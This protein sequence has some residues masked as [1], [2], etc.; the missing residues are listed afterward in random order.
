MCFVFQ[1]WGISSLLLN[2]NFLSFIHVWKCMTGSIKFNGTKT[3]VP[4][5]ST[6]ADPESS[7]AKRSTLNT[8]GQS[9]SILSSVKLL[10]WLSLQASINLKSSWL[11]QRM[12][13]SSA[14]E[15]LRRL[16]EWSASKSCSPLVLS[17]TKDIC[18]VRSLPLRSACLEW[19]P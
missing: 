15:H 6:V 11:V 19:P 16:I 1:I 9:L 2:N 10:C 18:C 8:S 7:Q 13:Y 17:S 3:L 12:P 5:A 14:T 4:P